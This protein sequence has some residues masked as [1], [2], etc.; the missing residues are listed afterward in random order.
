SLRSLPSYLG[1]LDLDPDGSPAGDRRSAP[2]VLSASAL[3]SFQ[4]EADVASHDAPPLAARRLH[5]ERAV[6]GDIDRD[7]LASVPPDA[8]AE[9]R[10]RGAHLVEERGPSF[11]LP[12]ERALDE[13][14]DE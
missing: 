1:P 2:S 3:K 7:A 11:P 4:A 14:R 8:L 6:V 10:A 5:D 9:R 13:R 12:P